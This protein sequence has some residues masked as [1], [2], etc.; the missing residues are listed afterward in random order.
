MCARRRPRRLLLVL[1]V[2]GLAA[3]SV[4]VVV[5]PSQDAARDRAGL[6]LRELRSAFSVYAR[7][8]G[9]YPDEA[10]GFQP[11]VD[12]GILKFLPQDPWGHDYLYHVRDG[13]P[14]ILSLGEDGAPGG[15]GVDADI[16]LQL[17]VLPDPR[18]G[19]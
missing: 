11:L 13:G 3:G 5:L 6:D 2:L 8:H 4:L 14:V 15:E 9:R 19:P 17:P 16:S 7:K 12:A 1:L 18:P 10:S